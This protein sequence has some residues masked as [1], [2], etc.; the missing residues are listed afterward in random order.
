M[1]L[2][3]NLI[4]NILFLA[5][6]VYLY[7]AFGVQ[8]TSQS[9]STIFYEPLNNAGLLGGT[10]LQYFGSIGFGTP[11][12]TFTVMFDTASSGIEIPG[13]MCVIPCMNQKQFDYTASSTFEN[14]KLKKPLRFSTGGPNFNLVMGKGI[15]INGHTKSLRYDDVPRAKVSQDTILCGYKP[16]IWI[17]LN[18]DPTAVVYDAL[19]KMGHPVMFGLYLTPS[20]IGNSEFIVGGVDE[21]KLN[22]T[23]LVWAPVIKTNATNN[24]WSLTASKIYVNDIEIDSNLFKN[25]PFVFHTG[26]S[27]VVLN[28][29]LAST[30]YSHIS[31]KIAAIGTGG[32][33]GIPCN[34]IPSLTAELTFTFSSKEGMLFNLTLPSRDFNMGSFLD[35]PTICQTVIT[36]ADIQVWDVDNGL[37]GFAS[38]G[39]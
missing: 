17:C 25:Q 27:N 11:P 9:N 33:Y 4:N 18:R 16:D 23:S 32:Y 7:Q 36:S 10:D 21:S 28:K 35:N 31:P 13:I 37:I 6:S 1:Y 2:T 20:R 19:R 8:A 14:S 39:Y 29:Q 24:Q 5:I 30:M 15:T 38:N 22:G 34:E 26:E 3:V 12:Q